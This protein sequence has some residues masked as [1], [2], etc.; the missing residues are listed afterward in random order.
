MLDNRNNERD[1]FENLDFMERSLEYDRA[2][3]KSRN[4]VR[5]ALDLPLV[6]GETV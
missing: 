1:L 4:M 5:M 2:D 6:K 3:V